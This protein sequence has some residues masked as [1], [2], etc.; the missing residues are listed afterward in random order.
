MVPWA[1]VI[2]AKIKAY[3]ANMNTEK[4]TIIKVN[5]KQCNPKNIFFW[6]AWVGL[7]TGSDNDSFLK[8]IPHDAGKPPPMPAMKM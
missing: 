1:S 3:P 6:I 2:R 8:K 7:Q 4:Q 5:T